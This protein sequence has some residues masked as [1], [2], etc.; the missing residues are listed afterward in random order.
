MAPTVVATAMGL[1]GTWAS[2]VG[3]EASIRFGRQRVVRLAMT[4]CVVCGAVMGFLGARSYSLAAVLVLVYGLL[5]WFDSSSLTAGAAGSA[6]PSRRGATLAL[7]SMAGYAGGFVG[8]LLIGWVLDWAGGMS[9]LG[10]GLAFMHVAAI[11][12]LGQIA[13]IALRPGDLAGDKGGSVLRTEAAR[14]GS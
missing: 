8:P 12:L 2:V 13:F 6:D 14:P 10:W 3:N 9:P 7:H 4:S 11:S 1:V 5:I